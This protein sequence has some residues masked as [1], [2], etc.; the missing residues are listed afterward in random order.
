MERRSG[1]ICI[2]SPSE[3]VFGG[4]QIYI[5]GLC[6]ALNRRGAQAA[7]LTAEPERFHAPTLRMPS[8]RT[9]P[10]R[11]WRSIRVAWTLRARGCRTVVLN[12]LSSL[13]LAPVFRALGFRVSA[14]LHRPL[15]H[16]DR[17]GF[18]H[19]AVA[20]QLLRLSS[21]FCH[22]VA[23]V[24]RDDGARYPVPVEFV[25]NWVPDWFFAGGAPSE[26]S[27]DLVLIAR[28]SPE[29]DIPL[30]L[31]LLDR[32]NTRLGAG[33]R[34]L[35]VGDGEE[36]AA[37]AAKIDEL[38]LEAQV[39]VRSWVRREAL[40]GVFDLGRCFVISSHHEGFPTT[41]LEAHARGL[42]AL[43]TRSAG[44]SAE[45]VEGYGP[46]TGLVF[47]P[48]DVQS[49]EF[50]RAALALVRD[51]ASYRER[52]VEKAHRFAEGRVLEALQAALGAS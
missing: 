7:I 25:G 17:N 44:F 45:F 48:E 43:V 5:D 11:L 16:R 19:G 47:A 4:G 12:D 24:Y 22:R 6:A 13:W 10:R 37:I 20:Y 46:S 42:P 8:A 52:C 9:R 26:K 36:R 18:G 15:R 40:P 49:D 28:F 27:F 3:G 2:Y 21:R 50:L 30:A 14:L 38:G 41:L 33:F 1:K 23:S 31:E 35:L 51:A 29:K 34:L 32:L 39:E